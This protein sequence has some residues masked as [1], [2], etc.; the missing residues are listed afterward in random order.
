VAP[1]A[2]YQ[3]TTD[4]PGHLE[5][6]DLAS[7]NTVLQHRLRPASGKERGEI[8]SGWIITAGSSPS[9]Y[10]RIGGLRTVDL[11]P[12]QRPNPRRRGE[13][14]GAPGDH[15]RSARHGLLHQDLE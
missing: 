15:G 3:L 7:Q 8:L 4:Y 11:P 10:L 9:N 2:D 12:R 5:A 13:L 1:Y 14:A 6:E